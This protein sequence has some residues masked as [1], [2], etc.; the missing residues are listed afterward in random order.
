MLAGLVHGYDKPGQQVDEDAELEVER[1]P[2]FVSRGGEKLAH[3]LDAL[4]ST[5]PDSTASTSAP[6]PAASPTCSSSAAPRA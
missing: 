5:R 1:P 6:R 3:A 2:P 4:A